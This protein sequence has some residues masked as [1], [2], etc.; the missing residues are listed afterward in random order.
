MQYILCVS[1]CLVSVFVCIYL[2]CECVDA[3]FFFLCVCLFLCD[4]SCV[5]VFVCCAYMNAMSIIMCDTIDMRDHD[6]WMCD[7][8]DMRK[9]GDDHV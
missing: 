1:V 9:N 8:S 4:W 6:D 7:T 2:I 3:I 5:C